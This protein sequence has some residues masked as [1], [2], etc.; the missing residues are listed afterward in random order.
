MKA[1]LKEQIPLSIG[2][3]VAIF[4]HTMVREILFKSFMMSSGGAFLPGV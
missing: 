4:W 1:G 2:Y 3:N